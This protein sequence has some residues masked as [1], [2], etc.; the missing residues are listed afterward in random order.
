VLRRLVRGS[1]SRLQNWLE[2]GFEPE[3]DPKREEFI[4][5]WLNS[6]FA[7]MAKQGMRRSYAWGVLQGANL[8]KAL[9]LKRV[10]VLEF[11]VAGG[12]GI[13]ALEQIAASVESVLDVKIDVYGFDSGVGLPGSGNIRD[14]PNLVRGGW[15]KMDRKKLEERLQRAKLL[16]GQIEDTVPE[17]VKANPAPVA[18]IACDLV[19]YTSTI[20]ALHLFDAPCQMLLPRIYSYFD[21]TLGFTFGDC[22]GERLAIAEFNTSHTHRKLSPI[23]GLRYYLPERLA[24]EG[25]V[26]KYWIAHLFDHPRYSDKDNLVRDHQLELLPD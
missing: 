11:G 16:L 1:V 6:V 22:N 2:E 4:H 13:V 23:Y 19:L 15:L 17:F 8:G 24:N 3:P 20:H 14:V 18:F 5:T 12:N 7:K 10:S 9:G 25:W 21:D 26:E